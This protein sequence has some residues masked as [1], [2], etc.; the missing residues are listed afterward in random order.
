MRLF[1]HFGILVKG[2]EGTLIYFPASIRDCDRKNTLLSVTQQTDITRHSFA[3]SALLRL[4]P[5][6]GAAPP[7]L[8]ATVPGPGQQSHRPIG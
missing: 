8:V 2:I 7:I 4:R 5:P 3:G 1:C 6:G